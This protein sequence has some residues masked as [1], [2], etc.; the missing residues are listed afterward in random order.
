MDNTDLARGAGVNYLG[1]A[2]RLGARVPFLLLAGLL[3]GEALFGV[4]TFGI[5]IVETAAAFSLFGMKRSLFKFMSESVARKETPYRPI[6]NGIAVAVTIGTII[7]ILI[8]IGSYQLASWF[9]I[10]SAAMPLLLLTPA[11]PMIVISDVLLVAIRFTRQMRYEV[12]ARSIAEPITLTATVVVAYYA[13]ARENGLFIGYVASLA[14]AAV[15]SVVFFVRVFPIRECLRVPLRRTELRQLIVFTGPTAGYD[16]MIM[17]ADK[18]DIL[19]VSYFFPA[20]TVGVYGMARQF[21]TFTKKIRQGFDRI[22]PPVLSQS[23]AAG[24]MDRTRDQLALVSRWI[25]S[26]HVV[27][28]L[29]FAIYGSDLLGL[30]GGK[31]AAGATILTL[32]VVADAI[33]GSLGV[34]ELPIIYLRPG[35]NIGIGAAT[36]AINTGAIILLAQVMGPEGAAL[37]VVITYALVNAG[38]IGVNRWLFGITTVKLNLIKPLLAGVPAAAVV[39]A[40]QRFV[41]PIPGISIVGGILMLLGSYLTALYALGLEPEDRTQLRKLFK[42]F[43]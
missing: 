1:F 40:F 6:A 12:F 22:L 33:N 3:Y 2:A 14:V 20:G 13:G 16:L 32:L 26:A 9:R 37:S 23:I 42:R 18:V 21:S 39:V 19:L 30:L 8:G 27:I 25:L 38:R 31:F 35:V 29:V 5:T 15:L 24:D 28:V 10:P 41:P 17:L 36:L 7:T 11:I 4:Y 43:S 34:S